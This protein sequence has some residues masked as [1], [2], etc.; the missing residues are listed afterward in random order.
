[1]VN[2]IPNDL[3]EYEKKSGWRLL[4]DGKTSKGWIG[5]YKKT[6]PD[7]GWQI[8]DGLITVL[9]S[10]GKEGGVGGGDRGL[11]RT[12]GGRTHSAYRIL[13]YIGANPLG[14][15]GSLTHGPGVSQ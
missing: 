1:M 7:S 2:N 6:F 14:L 10:Q 12:R 3:T 9:A 15:R 11:R 13:C 4:F 5:A 8:K